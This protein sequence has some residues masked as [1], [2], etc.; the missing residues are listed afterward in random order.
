MQELAQLTPPTVRPLLSAAPSVERVA[1]SGEASCTGRVAA[2]TAVGWLAARVAPTLVHLFLNGALQVC[3]W[4]TQTHQP[5][6]RDGGQLLLQQ[7]QP[8]SGGIVAS[9]YPQLHGSFTS[10]TP[11][12]N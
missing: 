12:P 11:S 4:T 5:V 6:C 7:P 3:A 1:S 2:D 9:P 8:I 10:Y